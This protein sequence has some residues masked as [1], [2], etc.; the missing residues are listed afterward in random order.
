[1]H[2]KNGSNNFSRLNLN[3]LRLGSITCLDCVGLEIFNYFNISKSDLE[4][5]MDNH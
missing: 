5:G 1:M 4:D 2:L 3:G